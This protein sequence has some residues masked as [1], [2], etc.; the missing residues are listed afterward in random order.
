M[1]KITSIHHVTSV[2][3]TST[4]TDGLV[5]CMNSVDASITYATMSLSLY[6][7]IP[8]LCLYTLWTLHNARYPLFCFIALNVLILSETAK[9]KDRRRK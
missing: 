5:F 4:A 2:A 7:S 9:K 1:N 6:L 8:R 3:I